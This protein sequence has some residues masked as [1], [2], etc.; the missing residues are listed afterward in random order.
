LGCS[1]ERCP[2]RAAGPPCPAIVLGPLA[3]W[4]CGRGSLQHLAAGACAGHA[5]AIRDSASPIGTI[6]RRRETFMSASLIDDSTRGRP[7][8]R[9]VGVDRAGRLVLRPSRPPFVPGGR[10][11]A[12]RSGT[13]PP[14]LARRRGLRLVSVAS[15][16]LSP[17]HAHQPSGCPVPVPVAGGHGVIPGSRT[18]SAR[19]HAPR[20]NEYRVT[21]RTPASGASHRDPLFRVP[22][23]RTRKHAP[24]GRARPADMPTSA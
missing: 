9:V 18:T 13:P 24:S 14:G 10:V 2:R 4:T 23:L 11:P 20:E 21:K 8:P 6:W 3:R 22:R 17:E 12:S 7:R 5:R 1:A 19:P 16:D 15:R